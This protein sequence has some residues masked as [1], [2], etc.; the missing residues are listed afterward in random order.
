MSSAE[1]NALDQRISAK[2]EIEKLYFSA[3]HTTKWLKT[4]SIKTI[5]STYNFLYEKYLMLYYPNR[6]QM[7]DEVIIKT[8]AYDRLVAEIRNGGRQDIE[9][10][11]SAQLVFVDETILP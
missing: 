4:K 10:F 1:R 6:P 11:I 5:E 3:W 7:I 8:M 2:Q 9:E